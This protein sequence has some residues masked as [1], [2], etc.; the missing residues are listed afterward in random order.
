M[1]R[2]LVISR[3]LQL[4]PAQMPAAASRHE[5][6]RCVFARRARSYKRGA[7]G[8]ARSSL[9]CIIADRAVNSH[10]NPRQET[11][12]AR[13]DARVIPSDSRFSC[14]VFPSGRHRNRNRKKNF[15]RQRP[16][17]YEAAAA[18]A[19]ASARHRSRLSSGPLRKVCQAFVCRELTGRQSWT[20][21]LVQDQ[22]FFRWGQSIW[23]PILA[24]ASGAGGVAMLAKSLVICPH[25]AFTST[26]HSP[27][28]APARSAGYRSRAFA[29][30]MGRVDEL[31]LVLTRSMV[32]RLAVPDCLHASTIST[33]PRPRQQQ[34]ISAICLTKA[35]MRSVCLVL[36]TRKRLLAS[37][38]RATPSLLRK[39][40]QTPRRQTC[41]ATPRKH[42]LTPLPHPTHPS[43]I[44]RK[45]PSRCWSPSWP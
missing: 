5:K 12:V 37:R 19:A 9:A 35:R 23:M 43:P 26:R 29:N 11:R 44:N 24:V 30:V 45:S 40:R 10:A 7:L 1:P 27:R 8:W 34:S 2:H 31:I 6:L 4:P 28:S 21:L 25:V 18:A 38:R 22:R 20:R 41:P 13:H 39:S 42:R 32:W 3:H 15:E 16:L 17:I 14:R 33:T 36:P